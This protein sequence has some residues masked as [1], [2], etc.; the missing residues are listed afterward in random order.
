MILNCGFLQILIFLSARRDFERAISVLKENGFTV[1]P[2]FATSHHALAHHKTGGTV[3]LH[4]LLYDELIQDT[5]FD[6]KALILEPFRRFDTDGDMFVQTLGITDGLIFIALHFI[7]HFLEAGVG[8]RQLMDMLLYMKNYSS[9]IDWDRFNSLMKQLK[10]NKFIA[11]AI[12][13][14]VKY[15]GFNDNELP[16]S[17]Y[18]PDTMLKILDDFEKGG[19]FG[20][21]ENERKGFYLYY[22]KAVINAKNAES[23]THYIKRW[24]KPNIIPILFPHPQNLKKKFRYL[25][26]SPIL[27]PIAWLH[28]VIIVLTNVFLGKRKLGVIIN[29]SSSFPDNA[30]IQKRMMLI[31]ELEMI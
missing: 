9:E 24:W 15:L 29:P 5:W 2:M 21:N 25:N 3:E 27:Y 4:Y 19:I 14:G 1:E 20:Q 23:Y 7:K 30:T 8:I 6:N 18:N 11:H 31:K 12:G 13:I 28:R 16:K 10:Y 26:I 22:T 17:E